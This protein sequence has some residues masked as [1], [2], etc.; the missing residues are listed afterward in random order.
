[1]MCMEHFSLADSLRLFLNVDFLCYCLSL[2][3]RSASEAYGTRKLVERNK[4]RK[5]EREAWAC[6]WRWKI[7]SLGE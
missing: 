1:M 5:E 4:G 3:E 6:K 2:D 7:E